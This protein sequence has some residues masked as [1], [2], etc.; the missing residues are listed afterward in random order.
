MTYW[1]LFIF[2]GT[3]ILTTNDCFFVIIISNFISCI[4]LL[5]YVMRHLHMT[6]ETPYYELLLTWDIKQS[7]RPTGSQLEHLYPLKE[8]LGNTEKDDIFSLSASYRNIL[9]RKEYHMANSY[10]VFNHNWYWLIPQNQ[11]NN[12][13]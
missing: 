2:E 11:L 13:C 6:Y 3:K 4:V 1:F 7:S 12:Y 5:W 8:S 10:S 9:G